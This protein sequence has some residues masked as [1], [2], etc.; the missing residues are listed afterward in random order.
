L[1]IWQVLQA[2][3]QQVPFMQ[4]PLA[5]SPAAPSVVQL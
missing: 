5:Q 3:P 4:W 1:Q 2:D